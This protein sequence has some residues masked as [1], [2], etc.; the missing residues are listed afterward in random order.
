MGAPVG[1]ATFVNKS[2]LKSKNLLQREEA[3]KTLSGQA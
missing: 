1:E 2:S 3:E